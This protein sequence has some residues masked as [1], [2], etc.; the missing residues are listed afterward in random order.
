[1]SAEGSPMSLVGQMRGRPEGEYRSAPH[2][3]S[4]TEVI[5]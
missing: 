2:E 5:R 4:P 1:M 3:G